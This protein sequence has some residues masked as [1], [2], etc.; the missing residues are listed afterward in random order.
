M[1]AYRLNVNGQTQSVTVDADT[2]LLYVLRNEMKLDGPLFGCGLGQCGSCSVLIDKQDVRSCMTSVSAA[3]G[4]TITTLDGL[5]ALW[6]REKGQ[7]ATPE[8]L[9]PLQQAWVDE[10]VPQCGYCQNGM[11]I[12][13]ADLLYKNPNPSD[14]QIRQ[15][16]NGHLCRCGTHLRIVRAIK[17]AAGAMA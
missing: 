17:R 12:G 4:E 3:V 13:A 9:H 6:A 15:A 2:P 10:R 16:M 14:Q 1:P 11:I 7:P 5:S 8:T